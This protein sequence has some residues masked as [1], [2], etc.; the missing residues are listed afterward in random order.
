MRFS[1]DRV[2][3]LI[4]RGFATRLYHIKSVVKKIFRFRLSVLDV[5]KGVILEIGLQS[6][7]FNGES[8]I[9]YNVG[10]KMVEQDHVIPY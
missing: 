5:T 9:F 10:T 4:K 1:L 2:F 6:A 7:D 8:L 3:C